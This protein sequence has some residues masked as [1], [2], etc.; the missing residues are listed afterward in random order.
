MLQVWAR[1]G[2]NNHTAVLDSPQGDP[3]SLPPPP[4]QLPTPLL[5][6][7]FLY[8]FPCSSSTAL[9]QGSPSAAP[10]PQPLSCSPFLVTS[11]AATPFLVPTSA[12]PP[13]LVPSSAATPPWYP[14][15][16]LPHPKPLSCSA[17][18]VPSSAAPPSVVPSSVA[19]QP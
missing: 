18:L 12:G 16:L 8:P 9:I 2:G 15:Q 4:L 14:L 7:S 3:V 17:S 19:T 13:S 1:R 11:L 6:S 10:P 5:L